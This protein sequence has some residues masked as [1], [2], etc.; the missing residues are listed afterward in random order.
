MVSIVQKSSFKFK[1]YTVA[2]HEN[3]KMLESATLEQSTK[4]KCFY[5]RP[6]KVFINILQKFF[7]KKLPC[8]NDTV[9]RD[10]RDSSRR[11]I[12]YF[13]HWEA[14]IPQVNHKLIRDI[15]WQI[16]VVFS[17]VWTFLKTNFELRHCSCAYERDGAGW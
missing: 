14:D 4:P 9:N 11:Q 8:M 5:N 17:K 15:D 13:S 7:F 2:F 10:L 6:K 12:E 16:T 1:K 3:Q